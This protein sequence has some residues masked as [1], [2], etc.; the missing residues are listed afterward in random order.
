[1]CIRDRYIGIFERLL[2]FVFILYNQW[3]AIGLLVTAKSVFRFGDLRNSSD[4]KLTEYILLGSLISMLWAVTIS[5]SY[6]KIIEIMK[7]S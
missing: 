4:R 1:M 5:L 7:L 3:A 2:M 6:L